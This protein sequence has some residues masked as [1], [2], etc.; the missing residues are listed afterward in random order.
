[1]V[2][3]NRCIGLLS[4]TD[5]ELPED[6]WRRLAAALRKRRVHAHVKAPIGTLILAPPLCISE[7][8]LSCGLALI[9]E[10]IVEAQ[11]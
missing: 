6:S 8:D 1:M 9:E 11:P 4:A 5:L 10:A 2:L 7:E 3:R